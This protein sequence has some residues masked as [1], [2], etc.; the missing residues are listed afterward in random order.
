MA[1]QKQTPE[2]AFEGVVE[3]VCGLDVH[4]KEIVATV[5]GISIKS[6]S[7][8]FQSTTRFL[9]E[10]NVASNRMLLFVLYYLWL[11]TKKADYQFFVNKLFSN[12]KIKYRSIRRIV[13]KIS[14]NF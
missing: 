14:E 11:S 9:T 7:R 6:E 1:K 4:K 2:I 13:K 10:P 5:N 3:C 12:E 8:T